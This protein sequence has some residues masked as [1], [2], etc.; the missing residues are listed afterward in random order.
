MGCTVWL[1]PI[2]DVGKFTFFSPNSQFLILKLLSGGIQNAI[3]TQ[4]K[5]IKIRI[6]SCSSTIFVKAAT[7]SWL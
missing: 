1:K 7:G 3:P 2:S 4:R 6:R 5:K